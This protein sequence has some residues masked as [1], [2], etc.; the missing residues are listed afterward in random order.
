MLCLSISLI[1]A[2]MFEYL[3]T[4]DKA[5][6]FLMWSL[7]GWALWEFCVVIYKGTIG[8]NG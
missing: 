6:H 1:G 7:I 2:K 8:R 4:P 3:S 5:F